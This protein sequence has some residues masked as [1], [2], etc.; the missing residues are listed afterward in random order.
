MFNHKPSLNSIQ[1]SLA[2]HLEPAQSLPLSF[3]QLYDIYFQRVYNYTFYRVSN[4]EEAEDLTSVTFEKALG[5][6]TRFD[7]RKGSIESWL[8]TIAHN[9]V[10]NY[11]RSHE[12]RPQTQ[13]DDSL[14]SGDNQQPSELFLRTEELEQLSRYLAK[15]SERDR[16]LIALRF[17]ANLSHRQIAETLKRRE[18]S[19]TTAVSRAVGRLR[20]L[21]EAEENG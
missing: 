6:F 5:A 2:A 8:F 9:V 17:G 21:F 19:V 1:P 18:G 16:E 10:V 11:Y 15:L 13:L 4:R 14:E 20:R 3:A 7:E 12:R